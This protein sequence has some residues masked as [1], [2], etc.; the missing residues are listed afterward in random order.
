[1]LINKVSDDA[2]H[3]VIS[4]G[5]IFFYRTLCML[6]DEEKLSIQWPCSSDFRRFAR[7]FRDIDIVF[8]SF[9]YIYKDFFRQLKAFPPSFCHFCACEMSPGWGHLIT[10]MDPSVGHLNGILA[11]V[12]GNLNNNFQKSQMPGGLP[13]VGGML[14]L[15]FDRYII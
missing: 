13:R 7:D 6:H 1:M 9:C 2:C 15:R 8:L 3:V 5:G 11:R 14:K 12:G 4:I 10:W